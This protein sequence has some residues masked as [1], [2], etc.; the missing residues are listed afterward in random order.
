MCR[1][2]CRAPGDGG[3]VSQHSGGHAWNIAVPEI[4]HLVVIEGGDQSSYRA[5]RPGLGS[6][7][8]LDEEAFEPDAGIVECDR[9]DRFGHPHDRRVAIVRIHHPPQAFERLLCR[10]D[11]LANLVADHCG[12]RMGSL[13]STTRLHGHEADDQHPTPA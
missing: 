3:V 6:C 8:L 10:K 4:V 11:L 5:A 12:R 9:R 7:G 13:G 2:C 1:R